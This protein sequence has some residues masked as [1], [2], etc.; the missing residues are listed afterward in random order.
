MLTGNEPEKLKKSFTDFYSSHQ[1][2]KGIA[3]WRWKHSYWI[4]SPTKNKQDILTSFT[5][6]RVIEFS[7]APSPAD[8]E[9]VGG[10]NNALAVPR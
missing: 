6:F 1:F 4:C 5:N 9:F 8:I 10:D 7:S 3:L 2:P